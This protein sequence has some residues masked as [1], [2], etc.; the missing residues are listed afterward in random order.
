MQAVRLTV[1]SPGGRHPEN[2]PLPVQGLRSRSSRFLA[3]VRRPR[4]TK[5]DALDPLPAHRGYLECHLELGE[6]AVS[7]KEDL[8]GST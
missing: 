6:R 2:L 1:T 3:T 8:G 7:R 4:L 5:W